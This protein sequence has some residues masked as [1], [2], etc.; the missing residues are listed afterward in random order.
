VSPKEPAYQLKAVSSK[1]LTVVAVRVD[2]DVAVRARP[3]AD[4][5]V[6]GNTS[7]QPNGPSEDRVEAGQDVD[8]FALG[9]VTCHS[10]FQFVAL[11]HGSRAQGAGSVYS[12]ILELSMTAFKRASQMRQGRVQ[13]H[14]VARVRSRSATTWQTDGVDL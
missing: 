6:D 8:N 13:D 3:T 10:L 7:E 12:R 9:W 14:E 4:Q 2:V 11:V 5:E 1:L